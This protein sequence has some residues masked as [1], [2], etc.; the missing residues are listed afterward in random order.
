MYLLFGQFSP[1]NVTGPFNSLAGDA[2]EHFSKILTH[3][4]YAHGFVMLFEADVENWD[5]MSVVVTCLFSDGEI[6]SGV[7]LTS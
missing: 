5:C 6:Y 7:E 1:Y 4:K 3:A 2:C